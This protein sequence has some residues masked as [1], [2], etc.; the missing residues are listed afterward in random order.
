MYTHV[1]TL[2]HARTLLMHSGIL[3]GTN[4]EQGSSSH[5]HEDLARRVGAEEAAVMR[6]MLRAHRMS[7]GSG[8]YV[9][10]VYVCACVCSLGLC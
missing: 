2:T 7:L 4:D 5:E 9:L 6:E 3:A 1:H 10:C 8:W